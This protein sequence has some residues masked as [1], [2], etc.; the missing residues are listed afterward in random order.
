[1]RALPLVALAAVLSGC[2]GNEATVF[3]EGLEPLSENGVALPDASAGEPLPD[4]ITVESI[5]GGRYDT[6]YA[7]GYVR[8]PITEVWAALRD[9]AVG[10]DR[11]SASEWSFE[12][13][14]GSGYDD[15]YEVYCVTYDIVTVEW[16]TTWRHGVVEGT[17]EAP[18]V[19]AV[20]WQ[21]TEGSTILRVIEGSIVLRAVGEATELDLVYHTDALGASHEQYVQYVHDVIADLRATLAAEPLPDLQR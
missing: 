19:V 5:D 2:F 12:P 16:W 15:S 6:V 10:T 3:P 1:M 21:K 9:P 18:E 20:R 11:R 7:R 8:A 17:P 14:E 13:I 4:V